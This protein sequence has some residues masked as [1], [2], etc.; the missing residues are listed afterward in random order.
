MPASALRLKCVAILEAC[1]ADAGDESE[2]RVVGDRRAPPRSPA[3]GS[4]P[5]PARRSPRARCA[6]R[7][8][9]SVNSAGVDVEARRARA[10]SRSPPATQ[11]RAL[12]LADLDVA[13]VLIELA[14]ID[15]RTDVRRRVFSASSTTSVFIRSVSASTKR[16]WMPS[17]TIEPRRRGAALAGREE[18][19]VDRAFDGDV[20]VGVVEH[21]ERVLAAHL[22]LEFLHACDAGGGDA[23]AGRDRSGERDRGDV[24]M[25]DQSS[26][27]R[28]IRGP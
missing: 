27:R 15:H 25:P 4:P 18:R 16:S 21:D 28:P 8:R 20:E 3:R 7:W 12:L 19:A 23:L 5:P 11:P 10:S 14:L 22:E 17:V 2:R 26:R 9:T 6:C 24:R 1:R 13:Q